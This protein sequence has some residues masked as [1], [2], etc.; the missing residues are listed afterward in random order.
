[1]GR[2]NSEDSELWPQPPIA[3]LTTITLIVLRA[4]TARALCQ[5]WAITQDASTVF[6]W[7]AN[8][9]TDAQRARKGLARYHRADRRG[10]EP[11][12]IH[13]LTP[14]VSL[15]H[16]LSFGGTTEWP[17]VPLFQDLGLGPAMSTAS[18]SH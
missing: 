2:G 15:G 7:F 6:A 1:M 13:I 18:S 14:K 5:A 16:T 12:T 17:T 11:E 9:D 3:Q 10:L 4:N 8:E